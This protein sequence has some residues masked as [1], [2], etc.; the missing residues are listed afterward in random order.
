MWDNIYEWV[1]IGLTVFGAIMLLLMVGGW[2][3]SYLSHRKEK[4][5]SAIASAVWATLKNDMHSGTWNTHYTCIVK[6]PDDDWQV[7][8]YTSV[9]PQAGDKIAICLHKQDPDIYANFR[10]VEVEPVEFAV[11]KPNDALKMVTV[12]IKAVEIEDE[13]Q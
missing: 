2:V 12:K 13:N 5:F 4:F 3:S 6:S 9:R 7:T 1:V 10:V 8:F 11:W